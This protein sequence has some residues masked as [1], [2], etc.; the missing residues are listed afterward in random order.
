M[1]N[2]KNKYLILEKLNKK[3]ENKPFV[4]G[5]KKIYLLI[6][7]CQEIHF[8]QKHFVLVTGDNPLTDVIFN[9]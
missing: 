4:F 9:V 3:D 1:F 5:E 2:E 6:L 8:L 7:D